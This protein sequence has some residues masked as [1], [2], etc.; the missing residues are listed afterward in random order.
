MADQTPPWV[1]ALIQAL[2]QVVGTVGSILF[3][4]Y[5]VRRDVRRAAKRDRC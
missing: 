4:A 5:L 2:G 1:L 3:L